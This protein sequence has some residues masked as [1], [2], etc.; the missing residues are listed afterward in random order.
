MD[1]LWS[2]VRVPGYRSRG[3]GSG[4]SGYIFWEVMGLELGLLSLVST[5]EE[6]LQKK[7]IGSGLENRDY[8]RRWSTTLTMW[9]PSNHKSWH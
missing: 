6:L 2:V 4:P 1:H 8:S 9:Y 5:N 3:P 7:N